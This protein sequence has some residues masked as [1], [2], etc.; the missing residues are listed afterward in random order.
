MYLCMLLS[1]SCLHIS[2]LATLSVLF[3][4]L[5]WLV[6]L[7][8]KLFTDFK[9]VEKTGGFETSCTFWEAKTYYILR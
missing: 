8:G 2:S 1:S 4:F 3:A 5:F 9:T 7:S 6:L